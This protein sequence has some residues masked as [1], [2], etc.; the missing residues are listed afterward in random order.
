MVHRRHFLTGALG[1]A[2]MT[3]LSPAASARGG[4]P[5][6][7]RACIVLYMHGGAS[8]FETF[9]PKPGQRTGG[10]TRAIPTA[11]DGVQFAETLPG[12][13]RRAD[14]LAV[15]RSVTMREGN[16]DRARYL[17]RTGHTPA[18][19][20]TH[21]GLSAMVS[22][23]HGSAD[24]LGAVAIGAPTQAPGL[25]GP[26]HAA[27]MVRKPEEPWRKLQGSADDRDLGRAALFEGLQANFARGRDPRS[28]DA[29]TDAF[30]RTRTM[31][32]SPQ[33]VAFDLGR[34]SAAARERYGSTEFGTGCL[35]ARRLVDAG[36]AF[37]E[38][39][40]P[41]WDTHEDNFA[42]TTELAG[43][44]DRG[45][46]AL[47]DDL[48]A[49]GRID[50]TLVVCMGDFGR[51]PTINARQGRDHFPEC[52]S[53]VLAGAGIP[54]GTVVGATTTDGREVADRPVTV[55]DLYR[56]ICERLAIDPDEVR[57]TPAGRPIT[58]VDGGKSIAELV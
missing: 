28:I 34:E 6:H 51:A 23:R 20:V 18:G 52:N 2:A 40:L 12:L 42:K 57:M 37:V 16:H 47:L 29:H 58:T 53:V 1:A 27:L 26:R 8:Q 19:G 50:D 33:R 36:V 17:M 13:A 35:L 7:A 49:S 56:T 46:S 9:D 3:A 38:V 43:V 22:A 45:M 30:T 48:V 11:I 25:L 55:A 14:A 4:A 24:F 54:G 21:P 10:P 41:G 5:S 15:L 31:L 44:L 39:G 32:R